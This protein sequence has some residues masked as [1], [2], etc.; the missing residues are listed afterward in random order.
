V[1][2]PIYAVG[3]IHGQSADLDR[4]LALIDADG[5]SDARVVFLG[6]YVD[7]GP[8]SRGVLDRLIAG[9]AA[10]R[11]WITLKGNH[12]R[13]FAMFMR[14]YPM[15]DD[16]LLIGYHWLHD[17]IGG[18]ETL[19]SYDI[20]VDEEARIHQV[21]EAARN[22]VPVAHLNFLNDLP[23]RY[24]QRGLLFVHAGIRPGV[25]LADQTEDDLIW[26]RSPFHTETTPHPWLIVHGHTPVEAATHYGNRV[27]LDSGAGYGRPISV[28]VFEGTDCWLLTCKGRTALRPLL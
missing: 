20:G 9:Q 10:G 7:R 15:N 6:D 5:G 22:T 21:H 2:D 28:A 13:M 26:I 14:D 12:D 16:R 3:D 25:A 17:R 8:D 18:V 19:A 24:E 11:D 23:V 4:V 27:N 1:P